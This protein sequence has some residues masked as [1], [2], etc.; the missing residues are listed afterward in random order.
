MTHTAQ[1]QPTFEAW[2]AK[3]RELLRH[4]VAPENVDWVDASQTASLLAEE[5][6]GYPTAPNT[7]VKVPADFLRLAANVAAHNDARRWGALYSVLWRLT[8][9]G[10]RYLLAVPTDPEVRQLQLWCKAIGRDIHKMHAFVRFRLVATDEATGREQFVAWFE[11]EYLI[12]R[13]AAPFFEK[14]FASMD[15][16][17]L[18]PDQCVSWD[19][20][21]LTFMPGMS[22]H[23][24]PTA[25]AHDDL[26][27]TYYRSI[28]NPARLK[29]QAMQSEM[30]KKYWKNLPEAE[31]IHDL[32]ASSEN[33]VRTMIA[34]P[35]R[36]VKPVPNNAYL[37]SLRQ[38]SSASDQQ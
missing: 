23:D 32:I 4:S 2:R 9:G 35:E 25:D 15:W 20:E 12:T 24:A 22:R 28:F 33:R 7:S 5:P 16:S 31:I 14:R 19:G 6:M 26:W 17:I 37:K 30:P 38:R 3:A 8:H 18:T 10:E 1:I 27:R 34:T 11:P 13:L 21:K 36:P 29:I